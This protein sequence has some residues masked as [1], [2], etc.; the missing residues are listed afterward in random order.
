MKSKGQGKKQWIVITKPELNGTRTAISMR[1]TINQA[2][3]L[4]LR[5]PWWDIVHADHMPRDVDV[6]R[7]KN[8]KVSFTYAK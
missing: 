1:M 5:T 6:S 4:V 2:T 3:Q 7:L 8:A